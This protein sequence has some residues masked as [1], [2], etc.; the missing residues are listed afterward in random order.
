MNKLVA[1]IAR[2]LLVVHSALAG[3]F[4]VAAGLAKGI[5]LVSETVSGQA[6]KFVRPVSN[7]VKIFNAKTCE[8][9]QQQNQD[10]K[11]YIDLSPDSLYKSVM[12]FED[13]GAAMVKRENGQ[14]HYK[15]RMRLI[16]WVNTNNFEGPFFAV[17]PSMLNAC[18]A[19][20]TRNPVNAGNVTRLVLSGVTVPALDMGLFAK[21]SYKEEVHQFLMAP[22]DVGALDLVFDYSISV[23]CL[24]HALK[25]NDLCNPQ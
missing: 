5:A 20:L 23:N 22:Y 21:Y 14:I 6:G 1:S 18:I 17:V 10:A 19:A 2:D 13:Q 15:S 9:E 24:P 8:Y 12:Y 3:S 16:I 11:N 7:D 4:D 25:E